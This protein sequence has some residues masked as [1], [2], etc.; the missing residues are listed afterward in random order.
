MLDCGIHPGHQGLASLPFLDEVD[1]STVDAALITHFHLDHCAAVPYLVGRT[2][3][4]GRLLMTHPTKAI[5][6]TLLKDYVRVSAGSS[7]DEQLYSEADLERAMAQAEVI[8]FDQTVDLGGGLRVTAHRA[9]HVLGAAMFSV[10][11]GGARVLYTGDYSRAADRHLGAAD[12]PPPSLRPD[13][14]IVESTYGVSRHLPR[15][16]RERRLLDRVAAT[17]LSGGRVLLPIVALGRAQELLLLLEEHWRRTPELQSVPIYQASGLA[18]KALSVYQTYIEAMNDDV[19]AAF[20]RQKNPFHLRHVRFLRGAAEFDDSG[21]CVMM[22]TPSMLQSGLSRDLFEAWCEDPRNAV[23]IADFAVQGT[24]AREILSNP[25]H[26]TT[27][28]GTRVP[29]RCAVEAIS[30]SAHA[31]FEQT[32]GFLEELRP[33]HVVL[34]HGEAGEMLR[35]RGALERL[36]RQ[37]GYPRTVHT[38]RVV[39]TARI[40]VPV[41]REAA[42]VGRLAEGGPFFGG[43]EKAAAASS[44]AVRGVLVAGA[45]GGVGPGGVDGCGVGVGAAAAVGGGGGGARAV[46]VAPED[47]PAFT[48]LRTG[49][50]LHRQAV[51]L[52]DGEEEEEEEEGAAAGPSGG[53]T[54]RLGRGFAAVRLALEVAFEGVEGSGRLPVRSS[55]RSRSR[56]AEPAGEKKSKEKEKQARDG[57]AE[58][59]ARREL[60]AQEGDEEEAVTVGGLV[61]VRHRRADPSRGHGRHAIVEWEGGALADLVADAV[62]AVV[63]QSA[64]EPR[65][66]ARADAAR[67]AALG[68]G[69]RAAAREAEADLVAALLRAQFG[70]V[71]R[72][73]LGGGGGEEEEEDDGEDDGSRS[74][75]P[76]ADDEEEEDDDDD[77]PAP[78]RYF[79]RVDVDGDLVT[80]A[81]RR[82][83]GGGAFRVSCDANPGLRA[84]V[85]KALERMAEA[86]R[87]AAIA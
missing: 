76:S 60:E 59:E 3:F 69:D 21:P 20:S 55:S 40:P 85:E 26:V 1:L 87:P 75:S 49:R 27:K 80:V 33:P 84:R 78:S 4:G 50:V 18:R 8:D 61:T 34:V 9:G 37:G 42:V 7:G 5:F 64:G 83:G 62:V 57:A 86:M 56:S 71:T 38:P 74:P 35:L 15:E 81:P 41:R 48:K 6:Y 23:V 30:F 45:G 19:R 52:P 51:A 16:V 47:L 82:A 70:R 73:R 39:S 25:S 66:A 77:G 46:I 14:V 72:V 63:L 17:V 12:L 28:S 36:A 24:L 44:A 22:A 53:A 79:L 43:G 29:L 31:D 32:S 11:I 68:R 54:C 65:A 58:A 10:E 13:A 67:R 2:P